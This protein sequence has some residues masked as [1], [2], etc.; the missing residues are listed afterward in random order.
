MI[1]SYKRGVSLYGFLPFMVVIAI[2][3]GTVAVNTMNTYKVSDDALKRYSVQAAAEGAAL[4]FLNEQATTDTVTIGNCRIA[5]LEKSI[6]E[7]GQSIELSV[8]VERND[9]VAYEEKFIA[10]YDKES[11]GSFRLKGVYG[12]GQR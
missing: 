1:L 10:L 7:N 11:T 6:T 9:K 5:V 8:A 3:S 4:L 2:L 12:G